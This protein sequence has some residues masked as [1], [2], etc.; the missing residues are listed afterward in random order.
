MIDITR[1]KTN[2]D[3][4]S[5][6]KQEMEHVDKMNELNTKMVKTREKNT[7]EW[8]E[9]YEYSVEIYEDVKT[10]I[11]QTTQTIIQFIVDILRSRLYAFIG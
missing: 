8:V 6:I 9:L 7:Q 11:V 10:Y 2:A 4:I 3:K 1:T 5:R